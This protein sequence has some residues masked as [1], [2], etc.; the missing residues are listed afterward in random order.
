MNELAAVS[1]MSAARRL[2]ADHPFPKG[3]KGQRRNF[4]R[5]VGDVLSCLETPARHLQFCSKDNF[6][7][8]CMIRL[9]SSVDRGNH[10]LETS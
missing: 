9:T 1:G 8:V 6:K 10:V 3:E 4:N 5:R 2:G 7:Y